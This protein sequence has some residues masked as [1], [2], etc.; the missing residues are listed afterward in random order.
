LHVVSDHLTRGK[1]ASDVDFFFGGDS[2]ES[3]E[4]LRNFV[5][6][7]AG[8]PVG[9]AGTAAAVASGG[10]ETRPR[11]VLTEVRGPVIT[12]TIEGC[13]R[14]IQAVRIH[15]PGSS[16]M[17]L[18]RAVL[19]DFDGGACKLGLCARGGRL[20][21]VAS[22]QA[23][24][25]LQTGMLHAW[26]LNDPSEIK[27]V[28]KYSKHKGFTISKALEEAME[29]ARPRIREKYGN[30][31]ESEDTGEY[32]DRSL[33]WNPP[34]VE[35]WR[36]QPNLVAWLEAIRERAQNRPKKF[37][38]DVILWREVSFDEEDDL[39]LDDWPFTH[40]TKHKSAVLKGEMEVDTRKSLFL[41]MREEDVMRAL[42]RYVL[43]NG[44]VVE[45]CMVK[46]DATL[47][48]VFDL[49]LPVEEESGGTHT[50]T[51][52]VAIP[53]WEFRNRMHKLAQ[54]QG[55]NWKGSE[56]KSELYV[57]LTPEEEA[58]QAARLAAEE[59][60]WEAEAAMMQMEIGDDGHWD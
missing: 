44:L 20:I 24:W 12:F 31:S 60:A 34:A 38:R 21:L 14:K 48:G 40:M 47:A 45:Q 43:R 1:T 27:R 3:V 41:D 15:N 29:E 4:S 19:D 49:V 16:S 13:E 56:A 11:E 30:F 33:G 46:I 37:T 59:A 25:S 8:F 32:Y 35:G 5:K 54:T 18:L 22:A 42:R 23:M 7:F 57:P 39:T 55:R 26:S 36:W 51:H 28:L 53:Y 9:A 6:S 50:H 58:A 52:T 17:S 10:M 2:V